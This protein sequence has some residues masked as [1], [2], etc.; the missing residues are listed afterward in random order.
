MDMDKVLPIFPKFEKLSLDHKELLQSIAND[1][2]SSD[3]NFAGLFTWD[4]R[5]VV[6]VSSLNG[7]LVICSSDYLTHAKFYSFIGDNKVDETIETLTDY[8]KQRG[9]E[10]KLK[11][12]PQTVV[13]HIKQPDVHEILEDRDNYDYIY[14]V[15]DLVELKGKEYE[16]KRNILHGFTR[17]HGDSIQEKELDLNDKDVI[18]DIEQVMVKWQQTRGKGSSEVS[19]E[20]IAIKKALD[21][22]QSL[23]MRAFGIYNRDTLI[24]FTLFEILPTKVAV[25]HFHKADVGYNGV[26]EHLTHSFAKHLASLD[27]KIMNYEQDLGVAGLRKSKES[28]HPSEYIKKY[29]VSRK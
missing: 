22:H 2:P 5:E 7:N 6:L 14:S 29:I 27:V 25:A 28:F 18:L 11:L 17:L 13:K 3:F 26:Y 16:G 19:D 1:F 8:A 20:F 12:V 24:A 9:E 21:H 15:N 4:V 10:S 23:S